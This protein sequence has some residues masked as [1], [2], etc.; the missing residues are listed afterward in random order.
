VASGFAAVTRDDEIDLMERD[1]HATE[2]EGRDKHPFQAV[3]G[4]VHGLSMIKAG[5]PCKDSR[6]RI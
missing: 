5:R 2:G 4:L 6:K 1:S 3:D